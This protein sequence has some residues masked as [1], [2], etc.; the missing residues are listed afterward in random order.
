MQ[1]AYQLNGVE[2]FSTG[3]HNGDAYTGADLDAMVAAFNALDFKPPLKSGHSKDDPG[4]PALGWVTNLRR[5]GD[6]LVADFADMPKLVYEYIKEKRFN[7]VS[8]E[9]YWN[10]KRGSNTFSRALKAVALLGAEI[11]AV[12]GLR[13]LHEL[14]NADDADAEVKQGTTAVLTYKETTMTD[15]EVKKLNEDLATAKKAAEDQIKKTEAAE[16]AA[17]EAADKIAA[18]EA[19]VKAGGTV[20]ATLRNLRDAE[21]EAKLKT[22]SSNLEAANATAK[23]EREARTALEA[24]SADKEARIAKLEEAQRVAKLGEVAAKCRIPA[25]RPF[26]QQFVDLA[27]RQSDTKVY[28]ADGVTK[29][30]AMRA[31][32]TFVKY[33][34]ENAAK[35]FTVVSHHSA[36]DKGDGDPQ[37]DIDKKVKAYMLAHSKDYSTALDAVLAADPLLKAEYIRSFQAA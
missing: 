29:I 17:R 7:T 15:D 31:V 6:K 5:A 33:A 27:T 23:A 8:S 34:N 3:T 37:A 19:A 26:V 36:D 12:A 21:N 4:H 16:K 9:I 1:N 11:P 13:P 20:D 32:E 25:L 22:L 14:F 28:D 18:L 24:A 35:L 2:I 30:D 10:L